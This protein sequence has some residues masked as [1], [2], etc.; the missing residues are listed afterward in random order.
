MACISWA[1]P[2][3]T[4]FFAPFPALHRARVNSPTFADPEVRGVNEEP[5]AFGDIMG[6]AAKRA[7]IMPRMVFVNTT[8]DFFFFSP[9][10]HRSDAPGESVRRTNLFPQM[11]ASTKWQAPP[12]ALITGTADCKYP[13]ASL[14]WHPR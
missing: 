7:G 12:H 4:S 14:D 3:G 5:L 1:P 10:G 9:S 11:C 2:R 13:Y 6:E 8:T